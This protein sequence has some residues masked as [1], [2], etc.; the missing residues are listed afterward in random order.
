[1]LRFVNAFSSMISQIFTSALFVGYSAVAFVAFS[2]VIFCRLL[3]S[4]TG[5]Q[6]NDD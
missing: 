1:M 6:S 5:V 2:W 3:Y 4:L